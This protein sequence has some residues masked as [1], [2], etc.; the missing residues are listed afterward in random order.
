MNPSFLLGNLE[1]TTLAGGACVGVA[2]LQREE[3]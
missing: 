1:Q 2:Q 3:A